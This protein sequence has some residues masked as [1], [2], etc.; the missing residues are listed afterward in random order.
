MSDFT[1]VIKTD[2]NYNEVSGTLLR[3]LCQPDSSVVMRIECNN[4][5]QYW[6]N[7]LKNN[8]NNGGYNIATYP[9]NEINNT[10]EINQSVMAQNFTAE[11]DTH[12]ID[13]TANNNYHKDGRESDDKLITY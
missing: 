13:I 9:D 12:L 2:I 4:N 7:D 11:T 5:N 10:A 1:F 6:I 3:V 8:S